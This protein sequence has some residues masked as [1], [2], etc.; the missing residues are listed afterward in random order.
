M[1]QTHTHTNSARFPIVSANASLLLAPSSSK[2]RG[3][4]LRHNQW[5]QWA[6]REGRQVVMV[7]IRFCLIPSPRFPFQNLFLISFYFFSVHFV[8]VHLISFFCVPHFCVWT[9]KHLSCSLGLGG[10][11]CLQLFSSS[12]A[13]QHFFVGKFS[14]T[15]SMFYSQYI[16]MLFCICFLNWLVA[17]CLSASYLI[18]TFSWNLNSVAQNYK[19]GGSI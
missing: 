11:F 6:G 7:R 5:W 14:M 2:L 9:L 17:C 19:L 13:F 3:G 15:F 1:T 10:F 8:L 4:L 12:E 18:N 16:S